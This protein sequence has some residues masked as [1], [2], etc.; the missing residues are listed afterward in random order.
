[1]VPSKGHG[2]WESPF[3]YF[4]GHGAAG[5][6]YN[7]DLIV[8]HAIQV[9]NLLQKHNGNLFLLSAFAV[10]SLFMGAAAAIISGQRVL[11]MYVKAS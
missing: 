11:Y 4:M 5:G 1:M 6:L 2:L 10:R 3:E 7:L 9:L 8:S